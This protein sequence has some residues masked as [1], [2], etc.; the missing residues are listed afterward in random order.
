MASVHFVPTQ[1]PQSNI[2]RFKRITNNEE[3][4]V[5]KSNLLEVSVTQ[6]NDSLVITNPNIQ[7]SSD[8]NDQKMHSKKEFTSEQ[9]HIRINQSR[10]LTNNGI[11]TVVADQGDHS[12]PIEE[13]NKMSNSSP[14]IHTERND[15]ICPPLRPIKGRRMHM[16]NHTSINSDEFENIQQND[17]TLV[18]QQLSDIKCRKFKRY[19][20]S[21][22]AFLFSHIGLCLVVV[23]YCSLGAFLFRSIEQKHQ[24]NVIRN[25]TTELAKRQINV[26]NL[27][28]NYHYESL[29]LCNEHVK[30][31]FQNEIKW[32]NDMIKVLVYYG[33]STNPENLKIEF[34]KMSKQ[35]IK[36]I[37]STTQINLS[38]DTNINMTVLNEL[39]KN[40]TINLKYQ[41]EQ[42]MFK[43]NQVIENLIHA[44]Y[45]AC[46]AGW[47][48]VHS[49]N[50]YLIYK[51]YQN[52]ISQCYKHQNCTL[53]NYDN[54][55]KIKNNNIN[56]S[57]NSIC[58][59]LNESMC[60][61]DNVTKLDNHSNSI[62]TTTIL[63]EY[64]DPWT[65]T[66][67]LLYAVTVIT[68]IGYGHIVPK[69][70]LGRAT[71]VVYALFGIPLV[72]LCLA[73]LGGFL[74][75]T[76][77][78]IYANSCLKYHEHRVKKKLSKQHTPLILPILKNEDF[79]QPPKRKLLNRKTK[80][81]LTTNTIH[82]KTELPT[83]TNYVDQNKY[84]S[85]ES[86]NKQHIN[87]YHA[88]RF[89]R[90]AQSI[91]HT[92][93]SSQS[94]ISSNMHKVKKTNEVHVPM[95]L[96]LLVFFIYMTVGAIIFANWESW[97]L[98][99]SAYFVF[100]T[101]STIGF[102]D[103]VP[104]I[105]TDKWHENSTKPVFC[106]FY[107]LFGLSMVAMSFNLM[108]EEVRAKFR[109]FAYKVGLIEE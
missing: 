43:T 6:S 82:D 55:N 105:Q 27:L 98:L 78:I 8:E 46:N 49:I 3:K 88:V 83:I 74:A 15:D 52:I 59:C 92:L 18:K 24:A 100:I 20:K 7:N 77:R 19:L 12:K 89:E 66:G 21:L 75:D 85:K 104:G 108:Q 99:Q 90:R 63:E 106:C 1:V 58:N 91:L 71:T 5:N 22:I 72:L 28:I 87:D 86:I 30:N 16:F 56:H 47:K 42:I 69:T 26:H 96:T 79:I 103:F 70:D 37:E 25:C 73:N 80:N 97:N 61:C 101:L 54:D 14:E 17:S 45:A 10:T 31:W 65:L 84:T 29:K 34:E 9:C 102:G 53:E 35:L 13:K 33:F 68:T 109:R 94:I 62:S 23:G 39:N 32:K 41:T 60:L 2:P 11:T 40:I 57:K 64:R 107:L 38:F 4:I 93:T 81:H 44:T 36:P 76:V 51:N 67:A 95:W 50:N 48:P